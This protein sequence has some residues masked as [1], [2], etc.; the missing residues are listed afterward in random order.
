MMTR[1]VVMKATACR[2]R[3][4]R[5]V[6]TIPARRPLLFKDDYPRIIDRSIDYFGGD[7]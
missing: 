7:A 3:A 2:V 1:I 5:V 6:P 4:L